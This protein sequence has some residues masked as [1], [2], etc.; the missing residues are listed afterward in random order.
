[1]RHNLNIYL[2]W[3]VIPILVVVVLAQCIALIP[4]FTTLQLFCKSRR[5]KWL[6]NRK[7]LLMFTIS[8]V[9]LRGFEQRKV[10][11]KRSYFIGDQHIPV[12]LVKSI[13]TF[14]YPAVVITVALA[15]IT[16]WGVFLIE[17]T[18]ACDPGLD[19]FPFTE[20]GKELQ[21]YPIVNCSDFESADNV[22]VVC[23]RFALKYAEGAGA[24]GGVLAFTAFLTTAYTSALFF[25]A[26]LMWPGNEDSDDDEDL[27]DKDDSDNKL[28]QEKKSRKCCGWYR[29]CSCTYSSTCPLVPFTLIAC[30]PLVFAI[31]IPLV[32]LSVSFFNKILLKTISSRIQFFSYSFSFGCISFCSVLGIRRIVWNRL[33]NW[34]RSNTSTPAENR[35]IMSNTIQS[36][37]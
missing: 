2:H 20:A 22:T 33:Q 25:A 35:P 4:I 27:I 18:F 15:I 7:Y 10:N 17:E 21:G 30:L 29:T 37:V 24:A 14:L 3:D 34:D 9:I 19:C 5:C 32:V 6:R 31:M 12:I 36:Y 8:K 13:V 26:R 28:I 11:G 1:M 16:F 23:Y